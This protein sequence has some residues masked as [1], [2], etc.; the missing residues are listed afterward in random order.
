MKSYSVELTSTASRYKHSRCEHNTGTFC[1]GQYSFIITRTLV[2]IIVHIQSMC[3]TTWPPQFCGLA[4]TCICQ[5]A[6][7]SGL[8]NTAALTRT[9]P[10]ATLTKVAT[11][12]RLKRVFSGV[13]IILTLWRVRG[14]GSARWGV[15][16]AG[17]RAV[18]HVPL[19]QIGGLRTRQ[20]VS[21]QIGG[22]R[23]ERRGGGLVAR[24]RRRW[25]LAVHLHVFAQGAR[26]CVGLVA[27]SHFAVV[28]FVA[29][30]HVRVLLPVA[31]VGEASI[32]AIKLAFE[33]LFAYVQNKWGE[34]ILVIL[35]ATVWL[36]GIF[37]HLMLLAM[38]WQLS[39]LDSLCVFN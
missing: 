18:T 38:Q 37:V 3:E 36:V 6:S 11:S 10:G 26:V 16:A 32:T 34:K 17:A 24:A 13:L 12:T 8:V 25:R 7:A 35:I 19:A 28:R 22:R 29:G 33:W 4:V 15:C 30:V 1:N 14:G 39:K 27:A 21:A 2:V 20:S 23:H 31:A 9:W 5:W